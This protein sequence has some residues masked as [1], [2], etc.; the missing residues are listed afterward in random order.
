VCVAWGFA[1]H[2]SIRRH[3]HSSG[4]WVNLPVIVLRFSVLTA[5]NPLSMS[6]AHSHPMHNIYST[7]IKAPNPR[8][9]MRK[10]LRKSGEKRDIIP[11]EAPT[12]NLSFR[13]IFAFPRARRCTFRS[14]SAALSGDR[15]P[16]CG[17]RCAPSPSSAA[18]GSPRQSCPP[19]PRRAASWRP[20][21]AACCPPRTFAGGR[22]CRARRAGRASRRRGRGARTPSGRAAVVGALMPGRPRCG[23]TRSPGWRGAARRPLA[24][25][26]PPPLHRP[27]RGRRRRTCRTRARTGS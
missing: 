17:G 20:R 12:P 11:A 25:L 4:A 27:S 3:L 9:Q 7:L 19:G 2:G 26:L 24:G 8:R 1:Q 21:P 15:A 5:V 22:S 18:C 23:T 14:A 10:Q 16:P 13:W 6:L